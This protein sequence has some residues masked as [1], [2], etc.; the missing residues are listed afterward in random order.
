MVHKLTRH[1]ILAFHLS[2]FELD[3]FLCLLW[4]KYFF[5]SKLYTGSKDLCRDSFQFSLSQWLLIYLKVLLNFLITLMSV[6][7]VSFSSVNYQFR[8]FVFT[9]GAPGFGVYVQIGNSC[10]IEEVEI[11]LWLPACLIFSLLF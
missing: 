10:G 4:P 6:S 3:W 7:L 5:W 2:C 11:H 8:R 9:Y 1:T